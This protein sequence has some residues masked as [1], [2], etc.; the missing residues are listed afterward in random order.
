MKA[1]WRVLLVGVVALAVFLP[2][3]ADPQSFGVPLEK[4]LSPGVT[5][6]DYAGQT[7]RFSATVSIRLQLETDGPGRVKL[8][9]HT[10]GRHRSSG[11]QGSSA[12]QTLEIVW[13]NWNNTVYPSGPPPD[14]EWSTT[15]LTESGF[16]EK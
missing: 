8:T 10:A 13:E 11:A 9:V 1:L 5:T 15:L 7:L 4:M 3:S 12:V 2:Q 16:T 6:V 14:A